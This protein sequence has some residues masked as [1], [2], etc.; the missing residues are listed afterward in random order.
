MAILGKFCVFFNFFSS[1]GKF[2][3]NASDRI[4]LL[5]QKQNVLL[6]MR[7]A[8]IDSE[9]SILRNAIGLILIAPITLIAM[10]IAL[11]FAVFGRPSKRSAKEVATYLTDFIEGN[12]DAYDWDNFISIPI[13]NPQLES[14]RVRASKI[15]LPINEE[16]LKMLRNLLSEA[17]D[18]KMSEG[19]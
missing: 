13:A 18:I 6:V 7:R 5:F 10:I 8:L 11:P 15:Q 2:L 4:K 1:R 17:L 16:R 12:G 14:I 9:N 3:E 19:L